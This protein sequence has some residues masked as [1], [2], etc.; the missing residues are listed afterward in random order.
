MK[1]ISDLTIAELHA[2][3]FQLAKMSSKWG[4]TVQKDDPEREYKLT[5]KSRLKFVR[6]LLESK[7]V[8]EYLMG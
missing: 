5:I 6:E 3:E 2:L 7:A 1:R 8:N 4:W